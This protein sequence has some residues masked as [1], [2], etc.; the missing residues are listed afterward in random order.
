MIYLDVNATAPVKPA[1]RAAVMEAMERHGNPSSV[2]RNGRVARRNVEDARAMVAALAGVNPAQVVFASG[3]TE[4]NNQILSGFSCIYASA[5]EHDSVLAFCP[6]ENRLPVLRSGVVDLAAA[7]NMLAAAPKGAL[8]S[9]MLVNNETGVIQ[10]VAHLAEIA[11]R[12]GHAVH[13]DAVQAAGR[14]PIDFAALG[15]DALTFSAHKIG[16][17]QGMGALVLRDGFVVRT[18]IRGGGQERNRRAGTENVA[19]I[20]GFGVAAQLAADDLRDMPRIAALRDEL[21]QALCEI[22]GADVVVAGAYGDHM[23]P[24]VA[25]T[26][27]IALRGLNAETQ[28]AS[29]DL[30][31][32]AVSAG[33]ACSSGK[34]KA[35]HVWR[36]MG[37]GP[38]LA[39]SALRISL[40]WHTQVTD[41]ERCAEAWR[42]MYNRTR[43]TRAQ[44]A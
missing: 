12:Y 25:N 44:A 4:A 14:L 35:S 37:Y 32:V 22:G 40:G 41:L 7:E 27:S 43:N 28:V 1:V 39:A 21:Q 29:M 26:L 15:V 24:R 33:S 34:V 3:G 9:L 6:P 31:G 2:H 16:G 18:M 23:A 11:R 30:A 13:A 10:P 19:G 17:P 8:V 5:I 42:D 36:A 20:A 38:D